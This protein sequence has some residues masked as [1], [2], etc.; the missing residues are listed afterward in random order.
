MSVLPNFLCRF[1]VITI[2][3]PVSYFVD[4]HKL[5]LEFIWRHKILKI[6]N[7]ILKKSKVGGVTLP[8]LK[9][10]YYKAIVIREVWYWQMNRQT[11]Q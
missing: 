7:T 2:R 11:D 8:E 3:I 5:I 4:I 6:A 10:Y 1:N 9:T